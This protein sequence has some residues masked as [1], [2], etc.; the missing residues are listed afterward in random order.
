MDISGLT[1]PFVGALVTRGGG[2]LSSRC[3]VGS[4]VAGVDNG[5]ASE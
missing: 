4:G 1:A 2:F 3:G 5:M